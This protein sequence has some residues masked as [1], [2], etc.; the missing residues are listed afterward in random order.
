MKGL[1][2]FSEKRNKTHIE[3][4]TRQIKKI[5]GTTSS[6][7]QPDPIPEIVEVSLPDGVTETRLFTAVKESAAQKSIAGIIFY[8]PEVNRAF[9][10]FCRFWVLQRN[11]YPVFYI[12]DAERPVFGRLEPDNIIPLASMGPKYNAM[13][14]NDH[15]I[16]RKLAQGQQ[17]QQSTEDL[18]ST[19]PD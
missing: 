3:A 7:I 19:P 13:A 15:F 2:I 9:E 4:L 11:P 16:S 1:L 18:A 17:A 8:V 5:W 12:Y 6:Q 14:I 10:Q